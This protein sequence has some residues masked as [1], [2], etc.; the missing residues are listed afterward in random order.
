MKLVERPN[1]R[2][3]C[4][5]VLDSYDQVVTF[6]KFMDQGLA[7]TLSSF[8]LMWPQTY[9]VLTSPP[10]STSPPLP[11]HYS[12]YV[13]VDSMG[14]EIEFDTK[15]FHDLLEQALGQKI[16]QDAAPAT[17]KSEINRFW[18]IREEVEPMVDSCNNTQ[19]FDISLPI[20]LIGSTVESI[21][22]ELHQIPEVEK[23][24]TFGHVADGNIH[25]V[26]GK[27]SQSDTLI[28]RINHCV[29]SPLKAIDGS[30]SAEHGIGVHKKSFLGTSRTEQ[31]IQLMKTIKKMLDPKN[32]LNPGK[33][34]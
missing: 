1:S 19:Q 33:V 31:E 21:T 13:L 12:Y 3:S 34:L 11:Y 32:I 29:Y 24:F 18:A 22:Q 4:L 14:S 30:I 25:F 28:D 26:V 8:E 20:P 7:G 17:S 6:L 10:A 2:I 15:R 23:V 5:A 27:N 9:K 16:I